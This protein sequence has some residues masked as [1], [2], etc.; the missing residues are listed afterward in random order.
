M[1]EPDDSLV[2]DI[3]REL[4]VQPGDMILG[5]SNLEEE[6]ASLS[7]RTACV[8]V[9][10]AGVN[11]RLDRFGHRPDRICRLGLIEA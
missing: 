11:Q 10:F 3:V 8:E 1:T 9:A 2:P 7:A 6:G 5:L 4:E